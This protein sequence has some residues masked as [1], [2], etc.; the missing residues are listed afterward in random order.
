M[1]IIQFPQQN[2]DT[3]ITDIN[4]LIQDS[5]EQSATIEDLIQEAPDIL[6]GHCN[7]R[8]ILRAV[9]RGHTLDEAI[10]TFSSECCPPKTI[11]S[12]DCDDITCNDCW[13]NFIENYQEL[14]LRK[15]RGEI[16]DDE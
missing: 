15:K 16:I 10:E 6:S 5:I 11:A 9:K 4:S 7:F 12:E 2:S 14:L 8:D 3:K 1:A 13:H